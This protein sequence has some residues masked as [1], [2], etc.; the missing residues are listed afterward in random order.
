[1][2]SL[3]ALIDNSRRSP[4]TLGPRPARLER[5]ERRARLVLGTLLDDDDRHGPVS[6]STAVTR[7]RVLSADEPARIIRLIH[8]EVPAA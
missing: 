8:T 2:V 5:G 3:F 1:M 7:E 6:R 4:P